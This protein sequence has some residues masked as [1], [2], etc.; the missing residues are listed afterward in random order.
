M[1]VRYLIV[2]GLAV[3]AHGYVRATVDVDLV[4]DFEEANLRRAMACLE[5]LGFRPRA[6]V[7]LAQFADASIRQ[8]WIDTKDMLV[9][10]VVRSEADSPLEV[11]LFVTEPFPFADAYRDAVWQQHPT[12][13]RFPFVDLARLLAMKRSA[14]RAK[15]LLDLAELRRIH[16]HAFDS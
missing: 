12:G 8:H 16:P 10:T 1:G 11:D 13:V 6:P 14:G 5:R 7:S 15:D 2:G 9:F 4:L 3:L